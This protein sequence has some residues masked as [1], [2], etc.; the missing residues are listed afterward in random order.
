MKKKKTLFIPTE[1]QLQPQRDIVLFLFAVAIEKS[2]ASL[3]AKPRTGEAR[4]GPRSNTLSFSASSELEHFTQFLPPSP[5]SPASTL[6]Q[7]GARLLRVIL[8]ECEHCSYMSAL[9]RDVNTNGFGRAQV[10]GGRTARAERQQAAKGGQGRDGGWVGGRTGALAAQGV[11]S[12]YNST[13][14]LCTQSRTALNG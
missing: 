4:F 10:L 7:P 2:P 9:N 6:L 5:R 8:A 1:R 12:L 3:W 11:H 14:C 13:I